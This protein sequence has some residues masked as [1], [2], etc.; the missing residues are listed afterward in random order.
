MKHPFKIAGLLIIIAAIAYGVWPKHTVKDHNMRTGEG[1]PGAEEAHGH[2]DPPIAPSEELG[3]D[4]VP[5]V[6]ED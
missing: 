4:L 1:A 5:T 3:T 2:L 6:E